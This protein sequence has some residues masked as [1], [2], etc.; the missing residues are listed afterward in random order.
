MQ[1]RPSAAIRAAIANLQTEMQ[2]KG[3][4]PGVRSFTALFVRCVEAGVEVYESGP[5]NWKDSKPNDYAPGPTKINIPFT[6]ETRVSIFKIAG[7][8]IPQ[9]DMVNM[10]AYW[11]L[12][13]VTQY[14]H[15]LPYY[16]APP[17]P[18]M[19]RPRTKSKDLVS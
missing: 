6:R 5:A 7:L 17:R 8:T 9:R 10:L 16:T 11:G 3:Y 2:I 1:V 14:V 18:K 12:Q 19:G 15:A 4:P 13:S